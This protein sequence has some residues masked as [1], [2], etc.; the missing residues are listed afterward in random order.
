M[1]AYGRAA[2]PILTSVAEMSHNRKAWFCDVWGVLHDGLT[3]F[4]PAIEACRAFKARGGEIILVTNSPKPS[5]AVLDRLDAMGVPRDCFSALVSSGDATRAFVEAFSGGPVFHLGP[6]QDK[7]LFDGLNVAFAPPAKAAAIVCTGFFDED[8]EIVEDYDEMLAEFGE[9]GVPMICANP[10]LVVER[11]SRLL[12]CAGLLAQRYEALGQS[13]LQAGKPHRPIYE[14]AMRKLSKPLP[15]SEIL[16]IGDGIDTDI[17][18]ACAQG[19]DSI[20][21]ASR[22]HMGDALDAGASSAR[23]VGNLFAGR[24]FR[25]SAAMSQLGW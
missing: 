16:A 6:E 11:G 19:I 24:T 18:G 17:K 8:R 20:Y 15:K 22:V 12:P 21:I 10:D 7:S 23:L 9:R 14:A 13:V 1:T 2:I 4:A 5:A 25:P 3:V